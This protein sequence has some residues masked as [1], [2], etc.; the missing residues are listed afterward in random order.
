[1]KDLCSPLAR[2]QAKEQRSNTVRTSSVY[3][4]PSKQHEMEGARPMDR[5][6]HR[7]ARPSLG[8]DVQ[9]RRHH[10]LADDPCEAPS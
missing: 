1:M 6:A 2:A 5:R 10:G 9:T 4:G 8:A 7:P 3:R